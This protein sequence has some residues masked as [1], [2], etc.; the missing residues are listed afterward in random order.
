MYLGEAV[1][2][3]VLVALRSLTLPAV[4]SNYMAQHESIRRENPSYDLLGQVATF[5][6]VAAFAEMVVDKTSIVPDRTDL[7][8]LLGRMSVAGALAA[9]LSSDEDRGQSVLAAVVAAAITTHLALLIRTRLAQ[10]LSVPEP[11]VAL[12]EDALVTRG[13]I[14]WRDQ[15][16]WR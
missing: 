11:V 8:P 10:R 1:G 12:A 4:L 7:L 14:T 9:V 15:H 13:A 5:A 2:I 6:K 16:A 3:G